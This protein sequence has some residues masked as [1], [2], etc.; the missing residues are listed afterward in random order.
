LKACIARKTN[1]DDFPPREAARYY[2]HDIPKLLDGAGLGP[3]LEQE[4]SQDANFKTYW[5]AVKDWT[6]ESR[7]QDRGQKEA[8]EILSAIHDPDHGVLRWLKR[9]W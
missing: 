7:Y 4:A 8:E 9:S 2:V 3:A 5:A 1:Q 6:E